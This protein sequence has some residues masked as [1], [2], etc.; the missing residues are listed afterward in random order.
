M[1]M[2]LRGLAKRALYGGWPRRDCWF[3]YFGTRV[4]FPRNSLIFNLAC[5]QGI[6]EAGIVSFVNHFLRTG[7]V[8]LDI[9]ANI[10]LMAVAALASKA[11][12]TVVSVEA[13][14]STLIHLRR[15]HAANANRGRWTIIP[16]AVGAEA[17]EAVF[18]EGSREQGAMGGL[19]DTGRGGTKSACRVP[20]TTIDA[21]WDKLGRPDVS[22]IKMDIEGGE[23]DALAGAS[24]CL[25]TRRPAV[26]L[27][28]SRANLR[29]Y[30]VAEDAILA[31]ARRYG[32]ALFSIPGYAEVRSPLEL[33]LR[34]LETET[35]VMVAEAER[36]AAGA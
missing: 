6:Y 18:Y 3:P 14:P 35:F 10:G 29:S 13:S 1:S 26:V 31:L 27:E 16:E 7:S 15:T 23:L 25:A 28:W 33:S 20:V 4:F 32:Y 24:G 5:A 19:R 22:V 34:M 12:C 21:L 30:G 36:I 9:G 8:Y 17:G 11:D 2:R